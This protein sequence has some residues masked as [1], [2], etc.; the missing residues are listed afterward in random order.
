M[1]TDTDRFN[2]ACNTYRRLVY[3]ECRPLDTARIESILCVN[4]IA[5]HFETP[6]AT[7]WVQLKEPYLSL[8]GTLLNSMAYTIG[9]KN[10]NNI[11]YHLKHKPSGASGKSTK[12]KGGGGG[13][14]PTS[15]EGQEE[16]PPRLSSSYGTLTD[17]DRI[18]IYIETLFDRETHNKVSGFRWWFVALSPATTKLSSIAPHSLALS[19]ESSDEAGPTATPQHVTIDLAS[20]LIASF[21]ESSGLYNHYNAQL[22]ETTK[23]SVKKPVGGKALDTSISSPYRFIKYH[24]MQ[25][26]FVGVLKKYFAECDSHL[27]VH[28][29]DLEYDANHFID[30]R[31]FHG[32]TTFAFLSHSPTD[33]ESYRHPSNAC[34]LTQLFSPASALYYHTAQL[35]EAQRTVETYFHVP[36]STQESRDVLDL[37]EALSMPEALTTFH[38]FHN[39]GTTYSLAN[40]KC[41]SELLFSMPLPHHISACLPLERTTLPFDSDSDED[42]DER[43][44]RERLGCVQERP[45]DRVLGMHATRFLPTCDEVMKSSSMT[46]QTFI[47][48]F[49]RS[50]RDATRL[51]ERYKT[52]QRE[53][54]NV[55]LAMRRKMIGTTPSQRFFLLACGNELE[56]PPTSDT[57]RCTT[58]PHVLTETKKATHH[59]TAHV[60]DTVDEEGDKEHV[61]RRREPPS[62]LPRSIVDTLPYMEN[63]KVDSMFKSMVAGAN[64]L[65]MQPILHRNGCE[66]A[67]EEPITTAMKQGLDRD[68]LQRDDFLKLRAWNAVR[69]EK[70]DAKYYDRKT[71]QLTADAEKLHT[72]EKIQL[73]AAMA[74]EAWQVFRTSVNVSEACKGVRKDLAEATEELSGGKQC[75]D[76]RMPLMNYKNDVRPYHLFRYYINLFL[77]VICDVYYNYQTVGTLYFSRFQHCR[78]H[79]FHDNPALN[80]FLHGYGTSGKSFMFKLMMRLCPS[81][82]FDLMTS[83]SAQCFNIDRNLDDMLIAFEEFPNSLLGI[84]DKMLTGGRGGGGANTNADDR[85]NFLKNRLTSGQS[86]AMRTVK[87]DTTGAFD[88]KKSKSSAQGLTWGASNANLSWADR[89]MLSRLLIISVPLMV[90]DDSGL[91]THET[92]ILDADKRSQTGQM[93]EEHINI[94]RIYY[95]VEAMIKSGVF[96]EAEYGVE[97]KY[98]RLSINRILDELEVQY[99]IKTQNIRKRNHILELARCMCISSA[100]FIA[101][102]SP[103]YRHLF[104]DP[105]DTNE[106]GEPL[107]IGFNVRVILEGVLP[108]LI[109]TSDMVIDSLLSTKFLWQHDYLDTILETVATKYCKLTTLDEQYFRREVAETAS[110]ATLQKQKKSR[111][112]RQLYSNGGQLVSQLQTVANYN[113]VSM[114]DKELQA[115][116][117]RISKDTR[118]GGSFQISHN[119]ISKLLTDLREEYT[120]ELPEYEML[121]DGVKPRRLVASSTLSQGTRTYPR[122]IIDQCPVTGHHRVSFLVHYL[123]ERLPHRLPNDLIEDLDPSLGV[124]STAQQ[125]KMQRVEEEKEEMDGTTTDPVF[126]HLRERCVINSRSETPFTDMISFFYERENLYRT[127]LSEELEAKLYVDPYY[128][129]VGNY[130][131]WQRFVTPISPSSLPIADVFPELM[132]RYQ[133]H[134]GHQSKIPFIDI[135]VPIALR[136]REEM[137]ALVI[138]NHSIIP[139]S[140]KHLLSICAESRLKFAEPLNGDGPVNTTTTPLVKYSTRLYQSMPSGKLDLDV[141]Y[142]AAAAWHRLMPFQPLDSND[143]RH[144]M[145]GYK[146]NLF[147]LEVDHYRTVMKTQPLTDYRFRYEVPFHHAL[148]RLATTRKAIKAVV[149]PQSQISVRMSEYIGANYVEQPARFLLTESNVPRVTRSEAEIE[150]EREASMA[151]IMEHDLEDSEPLVVAAPVSEV[152][153]A[154]ETTVIMDEMEEA[155]EMEAFSVTYNRNST[156]A[157]TT[158][159]TASLLRHVPTEDFMASLLPPPTDDGDDETP[160]P[161]V[162][163]ESRLTLQAPP[164]RER[165]PP[166]SVAGGDTSVDQSLLDDLC[167]ETIEPEEERRVVDGDEE[168]TPDEDENDG[169]EIEYHAGPGEEVV[170]VEDDTSPSSLK[171]NTPN[172]QRP[173][174]D[175]YNLNELCNREDDDK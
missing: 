29:D 46:A 39:P 5:E 22:K 79:Q 141:D 80:A 62:S 157:T 45:I 2:T 13:P 105:I 83:I 175:V 57:Y 95:V 1:P 159:T 14:P 24:D 142:L 156:T 112:A 99:G 109:I 52:N 42:E 53:V 155:V 98:A 71:G 8:L 139:E 36:S 120:R 37:H 27:V 174:N 158:T 26:C 43:D 131:P 70:L 44:A 74:V 78:Y 33:P 63:N 136:R 116:D 84:N 48:Q 67:L 169:M 61:T 89:D 100:V 16:E 101:L 47:A 25:S 87:D 154:I 152:M 56:A 147:T 163:T 123:K 172:G 125:R 166:S 81:Q 122:V 161:V 164:T 126:V 4:F 73:R 173:G 82:V 106:Q 32:D 60:E 69:Y 130:V 92:N 137:P 114:V 64:Y 153:E 35:H 133:V 96:E 77:H 160:P 103:L 127:D 72:E 12:K 107:Y 144:A 75:M 135:Q 117:I 11:L 119:D 6:G 90:D 151:L 31:D 65:Q 3:D 15:S 20:G 115:I 93:F 86:S 113:Y 7:Q 124:R 162:I 34:H 145:I 138:A 121:D 59:A 149:E 118:L 110:D 66:D 170:V 17:S 167:Q 150:V 28:P 30:S 76:L 102:T 134:P 165:S 88:A 10:I 146:V 51:M 40:D 171:W 143:W 23:A 49:H 18:S 128:N 58:R 132:K 55:D 50:E 38:S 85:V 148:S 19:T 9:T 97:Y 68:F 140:A 41:W 104:Y 54:A 94:H 111:D 91:K 168:A 129:P 108:H 21:K